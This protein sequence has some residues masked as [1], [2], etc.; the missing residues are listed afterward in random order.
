MVP[1]GASDN[2][3]EISSSVMPPSDARAFITRLLTGSDLA[4]AFG[5]PAVFF[6]ELCVRPSRL[7]SSCS[8]SAS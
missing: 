3:V 4:P 5:D 6:G 8:A 1:S 7:L 2:L